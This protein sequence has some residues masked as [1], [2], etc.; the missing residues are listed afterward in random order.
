MAF[1]LTGTVIEIYPT[2]TF[3]KGFKKRE[4]VLEV[5]DSYPQ[6]IIFSAVQEK[7]EIIDSFNIGDTINV[8]FD[9]KG[10]EWTDKSGQ[11][12]YFNSLEAWRMTSQAKSSSAKKS[13]QADDDDDEI[14]K[15]LGVDT[16]LKA[17]KSS[18]PADNHSL[19]DLP[20]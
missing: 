12:K 18:R 11:T 6:K 7:C 1:E 15:S 16:G 2:Q 10:R 4:F 19:D 14:F 17:P 3:N 9:V 8:A 13:K 5:G 20:F